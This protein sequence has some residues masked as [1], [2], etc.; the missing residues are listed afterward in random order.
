MT[1]LAK[2]SAW[3]LAVVS[4]A[5]LLLAACGGGGSDSSSGTLRLAL[6][7]APACGYDHVYVTVDSVKVHQNASA[8]EN[9]PGWYPIT[10]PSGPKVIG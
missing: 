8:G 10:L 6:T 7:D 9:D 1:H 4:A 5:T 3:P 2:S